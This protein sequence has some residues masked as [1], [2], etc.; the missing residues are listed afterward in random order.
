MPRKAEGPTPLTP[1]QRKARQRVRDAERIKGIEKENARLRAAI[2]KIA[3]MSPR[4]GGVGQIARDE[5]RLWES[6]ESP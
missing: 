5:I 1:A 4:A 2:Q 6:A 3:N